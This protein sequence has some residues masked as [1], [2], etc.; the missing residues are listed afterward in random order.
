VDPKA[1]LALADRLAQH[2]DYHEQMFL[3]PVHI[4]NVKQELIQNYHAHIVLACYSS[5]VYV[6]SL[7]WLILKQFMT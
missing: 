1:G 5:H 6:F 4:F 2:V 7:L 3:L